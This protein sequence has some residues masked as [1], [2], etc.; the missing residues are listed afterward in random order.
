MTYTRLK[1]TP[2]APFTF[3]GSFGKR[4]QPLLKIESQ[5]IIIGFIDTPVQTEPTK[6]SLNQDTLFFIPG[7]PSP[8]WCPDL[9]MIHT[10]AE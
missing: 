3:K 10:L 7:P 1:D 4:L 2:L 5:K 8:E 9:L 6:P